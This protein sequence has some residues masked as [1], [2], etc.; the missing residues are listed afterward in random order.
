MSYENTV[1][2]VGCPRLGKIYYLYWQINDSRW[3]Q[4]CAWSQQRDCTLSER[5]VPLQHCAGCYC[6]VCSSAINVTV[7]ISKRGFGKAPDAEGKCHPHSIYRRASF[8]HSFLSCCLRPAS[9]LRCLASL[10][11]SWPSVER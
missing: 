11:F 10:N 5:D 2:H 3:N 8:T 7:T 4:A 1:C 9:G 6:A